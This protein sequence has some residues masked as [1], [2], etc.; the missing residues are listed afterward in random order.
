MLELYPL[1]AGIPDDGGRE[2]F[3]QR[4]AQMPVNP[5]S[6]CRMGAPSFVGL[7]LAL[8]A[9]HSRAACIL[10]W[11]SV[12]RPRPINFSSTKT[13]R[14]TCFQQP[15]APSFRYG[16]DNRIAAPRSNSPIHGHCEAALREQRRDASLG[17]GERPRQ[18]IGLS[19]R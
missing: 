11:A 14:M 2:H 4:F 7:R 5:E 15:Q 10:R 8:R 16:L 3:S 13:D 6:A 1:A 19:M 18:A 17:R 12:Y 9:S